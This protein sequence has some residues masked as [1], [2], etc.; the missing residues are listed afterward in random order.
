MENNTFQVVGMDGKFTRSFHCCSLRLFLLDFLWTCWPI[1]NASS[2]LA[3]FKLN[4]KSQNWLMVW[5]FEQLKPW[6]DGTETKRRIE[7]NIKRCVSRYGTVNKYGHGEITGTNSWWKEEKTLPRAGSSAVTK[8]AVIGI[9]YLC[10]NVLDD[11]AFCGL[12]FLLNFSK[13]QS[14]I[15]ILE[16]VLNE[17][18]LNICHVISRHSIRSRKITRDDVDWLEQEAIEIW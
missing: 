7:E 1:S 17:V 12:C 6:L 4:L 10:H 18:K 15:H 13:L 16:I 2:V 14:Y 9:L 11:N 8:I 5:I 3:N